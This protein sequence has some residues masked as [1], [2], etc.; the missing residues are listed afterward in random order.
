MDIPVILTELDKI[1]TEINQEPCIHPA[2]GGICCLEPDRWT[3]K[4]WN[5][6]DP[7]KMCSGCAAYWHV[8][9][10]VNELRELQ[11]RGQLT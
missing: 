11:R 10:A 4:G 6:W 2:T 8:A 1:Q 7:S 9:A 5:Q 3:G